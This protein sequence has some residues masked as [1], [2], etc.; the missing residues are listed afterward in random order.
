[1]YPFILV[2]IIGIN[3][4]YIRYF[5]SS[6]SSIPMIYSMSTSSVLCVIIMG[7]PDRVFG[8]KCGNLH[9]KPIGQGQDQ[10]NTNDS[11][12]GGKGSQDGTK[13]LGAYVFADSFRAVPN[14]MLVFFN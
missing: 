14:P 3:L 1:M 6:L 9:V 12:A 8:L 2:R 11:D 4:G 13:Q 10:G 5:T 7:K